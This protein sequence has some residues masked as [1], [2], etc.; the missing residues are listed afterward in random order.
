MRNAVDPGVA[1]V[2][3]DAFLMARFGGPGDGRP[4]G[5]A[6]ERAASGLLS[7]P[8]LSRRQHAGTLGLFGRGSA[9]GANHELDGVGQ[10]PDIGIWI[11]AKARAVLDKSDVA[12]FFLKCFDLYRAAAAT[13]PEST[14]AARWWPMLISSE[15]VTDAVRR[16]CC[17]LS[18]VLC[19][20]LRFPLPALLHAAG[21]PNADDYLPEAQL[22]ELVTLTEAVC[23]PMQRRWQIDAS[24]RTLTL[25]LDHLSADN[26]GDVLYLQDELTEDL[27]DAIDLHAPRHLESRAAPLL[28]RLHAAR[29]AS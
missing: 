26:I 12:V 10:G 4:S 21:K 18:I 22:G 16:V 6:W 14:A 20:P 29:L 27:L 9:S 1:S 17:D 7:A 2:A 28:E 24:R 15:P 23:Q 19:D 3:T 11:E 13:F 8:G 5:R 25:K